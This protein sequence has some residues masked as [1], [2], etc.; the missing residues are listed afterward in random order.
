MT[1]GVFS[2][3][4]YVYLKTC[5]CLFMC[6]SVKSHCRTLFQDRGLHMAMKIIGVWGTI[7]SILPHPHGH[8][9]ICHK[10][11]KKH[12]V[13]ALWLI[14]WLIIPDYRDLLLHNREN[15]HAL[16]QWDVTHVS[17]NW[18]VGYK[19]DDGMVDVQI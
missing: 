16:C 12:Q 3:N 14:W 13:M 18:I 9:P 11:C 17:W 1:M 5:I 6:F 10:N 7:W 4:L 19:M 2:S 8:K 15:V